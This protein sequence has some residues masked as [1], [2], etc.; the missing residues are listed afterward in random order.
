MVITLEN[1]IML[2]K[3]SFT[4]TSTYNINY[5]YWNTWQYPSLVDRYSTFALL[6]T[7]GL[8]GGGHSVTNVTKRGVNQDGSLFQ[9]NSWSENV[10]S[11]T[12]APDFGQLYQHLNQLKM[13]KNYPLKVTVS[14][15]GNEY[16]MYCIIDSHDLENGAITF[17]SAFPDNGTYWSLGNTEAVFY[18]RQGSFVQTRGH[19]RLQRNQWT[20]G[21]TTY[22]GQTYYIF[23]TGEQAPVIMFS[24]FTGNF[25]LECI[26]TGVKI[27]ATATN[28][29]E[30]LW[31]ARDFKKYVNGVWD[32]NYSGDFI[33]LPGGNVGFKLKL[34]NCTEE[35]FKKFEWRL[36]YEQLT[37]G[38]IEV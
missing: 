15:Y 1:E 3:V 33:S 6:T 10:W 27:A 36:K 8:L 2:L 20:E 31:D 26:N 30:H 16:V 11:M 4:D 25:E 5:G 14:A 22:Y 28:G 13:Y 34:W 21:G 9:A 37:I 19:T 12:F 32:T 29:E 35:D 24:D 23:I 38:I 7:N 18:G 17:R